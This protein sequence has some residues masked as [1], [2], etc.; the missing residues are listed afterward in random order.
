MFKQIKVTNFKS[1]CDVT[2]DFVVKGK[3]QSA[4]FFYGE[5]GS[6]KSNIISTIGFL[7]DSVKTIGIN[8][9]FAKLFEKQEFK[10]LFNDEKFLN[11]LLKNS[12]LGRI[13]SYSK[14]IASKDPM[15]M[16]YTFIIEG[17]EYTY[18][19]MF[20]DKEIFSEK[21]LGPIN[22]NKITIFEVMKT[23]GLIDMKF[24]KSLFSNA[25]EQDF[26]KLLD[27]YFGI[28][29]ALSI[30]RKE[31]NTKNRK[32]IADNLHKSV[33]S[34]LE[35]I[36][37]LSVSC[38]RGLGVDRSVLV[39]RD[40]VTNLVEGTINV[41]KVKKLDHSLEMIEKFL[42]GF[43]AD[44][45]GVSYEKTQDTEKISYKLMIH[46]MIG[47]ELRRIPANL[48]S[49][50]TLKLLNLLPY[51]ANLM[52]GGIVAIDE[53]DTG[54]HDLLMVE[55]VNHIKESSTFGQ[56]IVSTHNTKL[57]DSM[58]KSDIFIIDSDVNGQKV[59]RNLTNFDIRIQKNHSIMNKYL[60]G[61]FGGTP[62]LGY[63]DFDD[64]FLNSS[65]DS[66]NE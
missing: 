21:L 60:N 15:V 63:V 33:L 27:Q 61:S 45:K 57:L 22:K 5:N 2:L 20:N 35:Y 6:G 39:E 41:S 42:T 50:G 49:T 19:M 56:L 54:I 48:E 38:N 66:N 62:S 26:K 25:Y 36:E 14:T 40:M 29:T 3:I 16:A 46:K 43:Y 4:L 44:I 37:K 64:I 30:L 11:D 53:I 23:N 31:L 8:E 24:N 51:L 59:I 47:N 10:M 34:V 17:D 58:D 9:T 28:H 1:L 32:Y 65:E 13:L 55:I 7:K 12:D 18:E 52:R